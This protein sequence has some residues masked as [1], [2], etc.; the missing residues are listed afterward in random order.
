MNA[1]R[2]RTSSR[3]ALAAFHPSAFLLLPL[4][5]RFPQTDTSGYIAA[6]DG[7]FGIPRMSLYENVEITNEILIKLAKVEQGRFGRSSL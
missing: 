1:D 4:L 6:T 2:K 5:Q 3:C 7:I